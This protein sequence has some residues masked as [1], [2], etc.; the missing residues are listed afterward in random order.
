MKVMTK[1]LLALLF[2]FIGCSSIKDFSGLDL[3]YP[4]ALADSGDF[5]FPINTDPNSRKVE[6]ML[7][8][9]SN[10][11]YSK[12]LNS[13]KEPVLFNQKK[14]IEIYRYTNLF[15][16]GNPFTYRI[17]KTDSTITITKKITD[18]QGGY[19]TGKLKINQT[20]KVA[21]V[22]WNT[23]LNNMNNLEFWNK[24]THV[25]C[26]GVDGAQWILEGYKDGEYHFLNRWSPEHCDNSQFVNICNSFEE[27]F[28]E[29]NNETDTE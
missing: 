13:L 7:D 10:E 25:N 24:P 26:K 29:I 9:F 14:S 22:E 4:F 23:F 19:Q 16:W 20:K 11:W 27:L 18:G 5:Y 2:I 1:I 28:E 6:G 12:H 3:D 21:L 8:T 17:V 15:T